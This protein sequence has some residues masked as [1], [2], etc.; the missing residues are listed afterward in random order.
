M[1]SV[2][3]YNP[4]GM[5]ESEQVQLAEIEALPDNPSPGSEERPSQWNNDQMV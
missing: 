1:T 5:F 2:T 3:V 4:Q